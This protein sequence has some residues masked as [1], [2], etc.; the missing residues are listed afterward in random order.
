[1]EDTR[2]EWNVSRIE[3]ARTEWNISRRNNCLGYYFANKDMS[4]LFL[5][6]FSPEI[7]FQ[8]K[9]VAVAPAV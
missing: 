2:I 7:F 1:M 8:K 6:V 9:K 4:L 3:D 5:I